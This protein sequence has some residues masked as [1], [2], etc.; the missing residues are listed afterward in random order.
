[1]KERAAMRR[2]LPSLVGTA[3]ILSMIGFVLQPIVGF[4]QQPAGAKEPASTPA[5]LAEVRKS[6][7]LGGERIP[8]EIFRDFGDGN[9]ADPPRSVWVTVDLRAAI[10]SNLYADEITKNG[11][12]IIQ[13]KPAPGTMSGAEAAAYTYI[14]ATE[15]GLLVV[16][17]TYSGGGT[18]DFYALHLLSLEAAPAFDDNGEVYERINL[19]NLRSTPLGDRWQGEV[20]IAG[21]TVRVVTTRKYP[22]DQSG[23]REDTFEARKP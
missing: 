10:G 11:D 8:P 14:G 19:T 18:G 22:S 9:L 7:T 12:W 16:L 20:H 4:A 15:N 21:N 5:L 23:T 2:R 13:R 1:V 6:F 17:S 3:V